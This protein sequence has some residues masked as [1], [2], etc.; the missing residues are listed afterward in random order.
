MS[1]N[2]K[3]LFI[4]NQRWFIKFLHSGTSLISY[5][6]K[7]RR[8]RLAHTIIIIKKDHPYLVKYIA[9]WNAISVI[10]YALLRC[11]KKYMIII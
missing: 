5:N 2:Y 4:P 8:E 3:I 6:L 11:A 10:V 1:N 9:I 7:Y